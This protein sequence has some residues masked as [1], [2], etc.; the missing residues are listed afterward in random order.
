MLQSRSAFRALAKNLTNSPSPSSRQGRLFP[1]FSRIS[2][3]SLLGS[4]LLLR[5]VELGPVD[6]HAMQNDCQ[7]ARDRDLALAEPVALDELHPPRPSPRTISERGSAE[8]RLLQIDNSAAWRHR[9][10]R[11]GRTNRPPRRRGVYRLTQ[12][13]HP[14]FSIAQTVPDRQSLP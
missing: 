6:P 4:N 3:F 8:P 13:K 5:P 1:P 12:H 11:F 14:H 7:L 2:V 9:I 10:W